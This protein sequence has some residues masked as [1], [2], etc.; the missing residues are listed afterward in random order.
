MNIVEQVA[1]ILNKHFNV[2]VNNTLSITEQYEYIKNNFAELCEI[3]T[4]I[5]ELRSKFINDLSLLHQRFT[6]TRLEEGIKTNDNNK[7]NCETEPDNDTELENKTNNHQPNEPKKNNKRVTTKKQSNIKK[8]NEVIDNNTELID[9]VVKVETKSES[10][11]KLDQ[12]SVK[13]QE[14]QETQETQD[15]KQ[16]SDK[17]QAKKTKNKTTKSK[18][19]KT[20]KK[21]GK[22]DKEE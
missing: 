17:K 22:K 7:D 6:E 9:D 2:E 16:E 4:V 11:H 18:T 21:K 10:E 19:T 15:E 14:T 13:T 12:D 8:K 5:K 20:P 3:D 1:Q